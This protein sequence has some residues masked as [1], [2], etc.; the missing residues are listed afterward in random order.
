M[1]KYL[2]LLFIATII[3][4]CGGNNEKGNNTQ[5]IDNDAD[6]I[7]PKRVEKTQQV[8]QTVP[9][10]LETASIFE[11]AGVTYNAEIL[12]PIG[13]LSNYSTNTQKA[14]NFGVYGA[15]LSYANIFDQAQESMLYMHCA[16]KLSDALGI[17]AA[18]DAATIERM[19]ENMN[20]RDSL[21]KIINDAYWIADAYLKENDQNNISAL[22]I[23]GG[24]IE[25]LYLGTKT[26]NRKKLN[27]EISKRIADQKYSLNNLIDL[28]HTYNDPD[29]KS[30]LVL[31]HG[32]KDSFDKIT[33][34]EAAST[35]TTAKDGTA[36]IGGGSALTYDNGTILEIADKIEKIRNEI[37]Q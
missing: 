31:L 3:I 7:T 20:N 14:I 23:T 25:G 37:I 13:N 34:Q 28:L 36:V 22:I 32:L 5:P 1:K 11:K 17:T 8:F 26:M 24:W 18:F 2:S 15:D 35:V 6:T 21:M 9:S 27:D 33:E 29:I 4:S 16:Q 30:L 10:P 19:E 12:N